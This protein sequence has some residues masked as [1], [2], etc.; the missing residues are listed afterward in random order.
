MKE[1]YKKYFMKQK[2]MHPVIYSLIPIALVATYFYGLRVLALLITNVFIALFDEYISNKKIF[3][4]AL[5]SRVFV[6]VNFPQFMTIYWT[7]Q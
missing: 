3:N 4:P 5:V 2:M 7:N 1:F 6:Y